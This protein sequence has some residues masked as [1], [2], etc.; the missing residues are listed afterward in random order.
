MYM[1]IK[2]IGKR[3]LH[4]HFNPLHALKKRLYSNFEKNKTVTGRAELVAKGAL[5]FDQNHRYHRYFVTHLL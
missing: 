4:P 1:P 2:S 5:E 3:S